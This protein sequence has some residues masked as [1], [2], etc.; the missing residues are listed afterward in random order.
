MF[1][2]FTRLSEPQTYRRHTTES[3]NSATASTNGAS[4]FSSSPSSSGPK[5]T[6]F[7]ALLR[8]VIHC[9]GR[10]AEFPECS[11]TDGQASTPLERTVSTRIG[12]LN[13]GPVR[14]CP[15]FK[16]ASAP[17]DRLLA[18]VACHV[19]RSYLPTP[20]REN[21]TLPALRCSRAGLPSALIVT[22][23]F[24]PLRDE[25]RRRHWAADPER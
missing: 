15:S 4:I 1:R 22:A 8:V 12:S 5:T 2:D 7:R 10:I 19:F 14:I 3:L 13:S 20:S 21:N 17:N 6:I 24:D 23:G 25:R 16:S 9:H 11:Q 18:S